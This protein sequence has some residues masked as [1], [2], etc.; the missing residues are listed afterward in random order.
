[1]SVPSITL[2]LV[3][4]V[5]N[6][7]AQPFTPPEMVYIEAATFEMGIDGGLKK[8]HPKHTV[9]LNS[10]SI[11][12]YEVTQNLWV[13][14]MGS[15]PSTFNTCG[16][17]P[18]EQVTPETVD[19][20][21]SKLNALT[22]KKYRLPTEAEW[23]YAS[24]GGAKSQNYTY[25]G[26]NNLD[27]VAW[28]VDNA[29][30]KTHPVG[31]KKPNELGLYDMSGNVWE[32][33]QDWYSPKWYKKSPSDNPVNTQKAVFRLVRGGSWRSGPERCYNEARNRNSKHHHISNLGFRLVLEP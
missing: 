29:D 20:F 16:E 9:K 7:L 10:Y 15:N 33:C 24:A 26:S 18:V 32:L 13:S 6:L 30:E 23:E 8:E 27:E 21:I 1:M 3:L 4:L 31:T 12:K 28:N 2:L 5:V 17:C 14:V 22:G 19:A 25:S 11:G